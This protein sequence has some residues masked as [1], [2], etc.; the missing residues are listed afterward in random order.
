MVGWVEGERTE[1]NAT[2]DPSCEVGNAVLKVV[3]SNLHDIF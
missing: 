3:V 1:G 2:I